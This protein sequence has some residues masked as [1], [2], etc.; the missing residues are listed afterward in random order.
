ML[1]LHLNLFGR[2]DF[3]NVSMNHHENFTTQLGL[4]AVGMFSSLTAW[5]MTDGG[6]KIVSFMIGSIVGLGTFY[7]MRRKDQREQMKMEIFLMEHKLAYDAL[8]KVKN[9]EIAK[10]VENAED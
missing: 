9:A 10:E 3:P 1:N 2:S 7:F 4:S 5:T 8:K 6:M